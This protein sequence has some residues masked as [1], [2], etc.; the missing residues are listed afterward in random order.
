MNGNLGIILTKQ[1]AMT[2]SN[3]I[4]IIPRLDI[5]G[6]NLIKGVHLEGLKVIGSPQEYATKYYEQGA[7]ELIY[8]DSVASL[9]GRNHLSEII[10]RACE[11]I[12]IPLTV[13]G[14]IRSVTDVRD[15]LRNGADKV[16]IN[17]AAVNKPELISEI[18]NEFGSQCLVLYIEAKKISSNSWEVFTDNGRESSGK[19]VVNWIKQAIKLG[20]GEILLT[21]IDKEGTKKGFDYDLIKAVTSFSTVPVIANGGMG[22]LKDGISMSSIL[23]YEIN[24]LSQIRESLLS[25]GLNARKFS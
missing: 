21:S 19:D 14:G 22:N 10:Q 16:A 18:A 6:Q 9:Y 1:D 5:K 13:G 8:V 7:D 25:E 12:F 24:K 15:V 17:T 20:I 2:N 23:H 11:N 3:N 4:R